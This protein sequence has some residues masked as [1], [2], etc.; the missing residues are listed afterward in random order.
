MT[1]TDAGLTPLVLQLGR[2]RAAEMDVAA[3]LGSVCS[4]LPAVL[5]VGGA[6][7]LL[8]E[9][10]RSPFRALTASDARARW[11]G[12]AQQ[13]TEVG[14]LPGVLRTWRPMLTADL[15]R[16][17]PPAVAAAAVECGLVSSLVLPFDV[18]GDRLGVLQLLGETKRPVGARD[19]EILRPL[20]DVLTARLSD[21]A[22]L[23]RAR[24]AGDAQSATKRVDRVSGAE[25]RPSGDL[26]IPR[27]RPASP[28][29]GPA[30]DALGS[31][32]AVQDESTNSR[33]A[34]QS[35]ARRGTRAASGTSD[36]TTSALPVVP[37]RHAIG[38]VGAPRAARG[39]EAAAPAVAPPQPAWRRSAGAP[40][41]RG[42]HAA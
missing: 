20:L 33:S 6:V 41:R 17:G 13:R 39:A 22:A 24:P 37:P 7:L 31:E 21:V 9:P 34:R 18:D 25:R 35:G 16:I 3:V 19:A 23:R 4:A 12:E 26:D 10:L 32:V 30:T 28:V 38:P 8:V 40:S 14:P 29:R 36:S 42:R 15:T 5:G 11:F 1:T 27:A 2:A